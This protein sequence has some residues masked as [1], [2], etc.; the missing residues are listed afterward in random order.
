MEH[1]L[2]FQELLSP[3]LLDANIGMFEIVSNFLEIGKY[4]KEKGQFARKVYNYICKNSI[5][6]VLQYFRVLLVGLDFITVNARFSKLV[7]PIF[8]VVFISCI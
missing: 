8:S 4:V 5:H 6:A 3:E 1:S 2:N 7:L